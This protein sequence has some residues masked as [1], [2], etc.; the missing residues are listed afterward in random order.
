MK[1][2]NNNK[3]KD[4]PKPPVE[5]PDKFLKFSLNNIYNS[6]EDYEPMKTKLIS[7]EFIE[8]Q[9]DELFTEEIINLTKLKK[10]AWNGIPSSFISK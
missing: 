9:F 5:T 4:L 6:F 2:L 10:L 1:F 7:D 8:K 3:S